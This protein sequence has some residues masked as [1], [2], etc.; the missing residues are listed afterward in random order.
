M[1]AMEIQ[2]KEVLSVLMPMARN[3]IPRIRNTVDIL[4]RLTFIGYLT[5]TS[6]KSLNV[7]LNNVDDLLLKIISKKSIK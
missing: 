6:L 4:R 1:K 7:P 2:E 5:F 3:T